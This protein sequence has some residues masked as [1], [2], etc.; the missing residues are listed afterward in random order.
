[1]VTNWAE[2]AEMGPIQRGWWGQKVILRISLLGCLSRRYKNKGSPFSEIFFENNKKEPTFDYAAS[3]E[4]I[5]HGNRKI[6]CDLRIV[7]CESDSFNLYI[8]RLLRVYAYNFVV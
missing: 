8:H 1:M 6:V 5:R 4:S 3:R 2:Q 7:Q